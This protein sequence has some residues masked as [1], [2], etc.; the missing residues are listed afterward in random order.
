[1]TIDGFKAHYIDYQSEDGSTIDSIAKCGDRRLLEPGSGVYIAESIVDGPIRETEILLDGHREDG[2]LEFLVYDVDGMLT[3]RTQFP[4]V[5]NG[6]HIVTASPYSCMSC[7]F[8]SGAS[9]GTWG[10]DTI[11]PTSGPCSQ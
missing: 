1:L 8:N 5:G 11:F 2:Q 6:P 3:N 9:A 10:F 4:T 7:H